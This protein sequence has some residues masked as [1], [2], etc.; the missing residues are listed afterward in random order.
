MKTR[1]TLIYIIG[2]ILTAG[3]I[4]VSCGEEKKEYRIGVSQCSNDDWRNKMNEEI[5]R[6][7][8]VHPEASVEIRSAEDS[9]AKQIADIRYFANN[10]FDIIIVA[11]NEADAITPVIDS[12]Y[13]SGIPVVVFDRNVNGH[14]YTAFQGAD[15]E[16]IGVLAA[17][18]ASNLMRGKGSVLELYGLKGSTPAI[19]RH[20]GFRKELESHPGIKIEASAYGNWK[21]EDALHL[22][23]SLLSVYPDVD[24]IYAHN[25]RMAVAASDAARRRKLDPYIIGIDAAPEI[26]M[27][28]VRDSVIDATFLYPTEG[29]RLIKTAL[30]ILKGEPY[31]SVA[32]LPIPSAVDLSNADI[33][34]IQNESLKEETSKMKSLKSEIDQYWDRHSAQTTLFYVSIAFVVMLCV[35]LFFILRAF[36]LRKGYQETLLRKNE[37]LASQHEEQKRLNTR[38]EEATRSKLMFFTNVSHDLRTPLTLIAEP[39]EQLAGAGNLTPSQKTLMHIADKNVRILKRLLNQI[40]DFR[41]YENGKL[42]VNLVETDFGALAK[43]WVEAFSNVA[44]SRDIKLDI[45]IEDA[46][47]RLAVDEEKIERVVYNLMSNALK[48]TPAN[49]SVCFSCGREGDKIFFSV[50][51]NGPGIKE[52]DRKRIFDRFF[53]VDRVHPKGSGIGLSLTKAFVELHG[54]EINVESEVGK[55]SEFKVILPVVHVGVGTESSVAGTDHAAIEAEL[56]DVETQ[57]REFSEDK[58]VILVIDD[59]E[60]IRVMLEELLSDKYNVVG[61]SNGR[62]GIRY[63]TRYVPDLVVCDVM[64]PVMDGLECCRNIKEEISTSHIPVL[65]LTACSMDEQKVAGY[66]SGADGYISKPFNSAVL[67]S[68]IENLLENRRRIKNIWGASHDRS[69]GDLSKPANGSAERRIV[70]TDV[71]NEFYARF[72]KLVESRMG[73]ADMNVDQLAS[74]MGLG[75]SQLYRKIKALTNY[76]PVELI[77]NLRLKRARHLLTTTDRSISEIAYEVGFSTPAY[78]SKCY[79]EAYG[80]TPTELR[81]RL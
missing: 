43:D 18:Y 24:C 36:W 38:L 7:I 67:R 39:V 20:E 21:Y 8:L 14:S 52:E 11:P 29:H 9:N 41:A 74:E 45:K 78:F 71:E 57:E 69:E 79:R 33:L 50:C 4:L 75:R 16:K 65:M 72:L 19:S 10:G 6:E 80:E 15:N 28:A 3:L 2:I 17:R 56:A 54:G 51:D 61:A 26:G 53:Q 58:P 77:R 66:E 30:A 40:L 63:A 12:V 70:S 59:N 62:E 23:D 5:E 25:D 1:L 73:D 49:G 48:Y 35:L 44:R 60:D 22:A 37:Q 81:S 31:D 46:D 76:S 42:D 68:R 47:L 32:K 55:G 27:K 34:L 13:R 64:M